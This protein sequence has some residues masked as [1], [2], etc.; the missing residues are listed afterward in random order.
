LL[1]QLLVVDPNQRLSAK[2]VLEHHWVTNVRNVMAR[3]PGGL[4]LSIPSLNM[5]P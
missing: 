1:L 4:F 5:M 3:L 2:Q